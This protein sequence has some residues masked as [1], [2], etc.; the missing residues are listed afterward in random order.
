MGQALCEYSL[1]SSYEE[2]CRLIVRTQKP[3]GSLTP[4]IRPYVTEYGLKPGRCRC[5]NLDCCLRHPLP[6]LYCS[7]L[8]LSSQGDWAYFTTTPLLVPNL[9][10][11]PQEALVLHTGSQRLQ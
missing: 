3:R 4:A 10:P 8:I 2:L 5:A 6:I 11:I 1:I 9:P 7:Q